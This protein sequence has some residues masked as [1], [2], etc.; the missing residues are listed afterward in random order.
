MENRI[1][2]TNV[3]KLK[4]KMTFKFKI[5]GFIILASCLLSAFECSSS[6]TK[7]GDKKKNETD[8]NFNPYFPLKEG[9][10]WEYINEAPRKETEYFT[11][12][13]S[14]IRKTED[15]SMVNL[16]SFPYFTK[17]SA[18]K[19][20]TVRSNGDIEI[21]DYMGSSGVII[22]SQENFKKDYKWTFGIFGGSI[23]SD[24]EKVMTESGEFDGCYY[25]LMTDGFT[26][27]FEFWYKKDIGIVKWG[28]NRTNPP[29]FKPVYYV[30]K[31]YKLN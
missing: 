9:N 8:L 16:S 19:T 10:Y 28:A 26:F 30:L 27:S 2:K 15:G 17:E 1:F 12:K 4:S 25:V 29:T 18:P 24:G 6:Y 21:K 7:T 31:E 14:D 11:V 13:A 23:N 5:I 3:K 22:P 20:I